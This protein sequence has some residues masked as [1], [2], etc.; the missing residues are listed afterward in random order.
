[1]CWVC[2]WYINGKIAIVKKT[3]ET[4]FSKTGR[5]VMYVCLLRNIIVDPEGTTHDHSVP[6]NF[7]NLCI[8]SD[9]N[10]C[11]Q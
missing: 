2:F 5:I 9:H 1:M 8:L 7:T 3:I 6:G 10:K 11:Q 4:N